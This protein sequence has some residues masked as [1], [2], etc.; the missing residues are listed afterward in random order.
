MNSIKKNKTL[1]FIIVILLLTNVMMLIFFFTMTGAGKAEEPKRISFTE[2]LKTQVGFSEEQ[3]AAYEPKR[4]EF[5]K[6]MRQ[7]FDSIRDTKKQF[8]FLIYNPSVP[9]S[10]LVERSELIGDQQKNLDLRVIRYYKD[11][12]TLCTPEQLPKFDSLIPPIIERM[13][14]PGKR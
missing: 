6:E 14:R 9:D 11:V 3:I 10:A 5:W 7:R 13:V 4:N 2:R 8:Y 12:R 1:L